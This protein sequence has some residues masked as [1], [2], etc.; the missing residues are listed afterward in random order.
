MRTA[1]LVRLWGFNAVPPAVKEIPIHFPAISQT[2]QA[3][4]ATANL[5]TAVS[6]SV[7]S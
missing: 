1:P 6:S 4:S 7:V 3:R 2:I 5:R